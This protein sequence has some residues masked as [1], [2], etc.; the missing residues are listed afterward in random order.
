MNLSEKIE[1]GKDIQCKYTL[2]FIK[3]ENKFLMLNRVKAP[4]MGLWNGVG[5]KIEINE[6][7]FTGIKR[8]ITE[9]TGLII[10]EVKYHG[11]VFWHS[12]DFVGGMHVFTAD[13]PHKIPYE[14][15]I[16]KDEGILSWK[17]LEWVFHPEN[18]GIISNIP[19]FLDKMM[20]SEKTLNFEFIYDENE[21]IKSYTFQVIDY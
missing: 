14:T 12:G 11:D 5:G 13:F 10:E 4:N 15:P 1:I 21:H 17:S 9:E 3:K 8:E 7:K 20:K 18:K 16:E 6:D 2:C 19:I